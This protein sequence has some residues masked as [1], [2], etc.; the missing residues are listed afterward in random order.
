MKKINIIVMNIAGL[1]L[2]IAVVLKSQQLLSEPIMSKGFWESWEFFLVQIPLELGLAIWL[3]S[4][5]FRKAAWLI[6]TISFGGFIAVT[7]AKALGGVESCGC[8]GSVHVD[9]WITLLAVDVPIFLLLL[10]FRP[11]GCKLLPPPWPKPAHFLAIAIPT[12]ILLPVLEI[13]II[14]NRP[15]DKTDEY[16]VV[17]TADWTKPARQEPIAEVNSS[18]PNVALVPA[19]N[20]V[21]VSPIN[22]V[23]EANAPAEP[24]E[25][26]VRWPMLEHI[27]I[28]ETLGSGIWVVLMYHTDCPDCADAVPEYEQFQR[29]LAGNDDAI[30]FA[31]I[32][33]PPYAEPG[34]GPVPGDSICTL[35]RL[36][37]AKKWFVQSPLVVVLLDGRVLGVWEGNA[38]NLDE[39]FEAAFNN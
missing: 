11:L 12:F 22:V 3:L 19:A 25:Q 13:T 4:G 14:F 34:T 30:R 6:T 38:P 2:L 29:S 31:F 10:V 36:S 23:V 7:L 5:L 15:P 39:I 27:N 28:A 35:G 37:D 26:L 9:P 16:E 33:M 20:D 1:F 18:E 21:N 8:F 32:G 17:N 24:P